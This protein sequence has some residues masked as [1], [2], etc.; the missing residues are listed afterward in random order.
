MNWMPFVLLVRWQESQRPERRGPLRAW[1]SRMLSRLNELMIAILALILLLLLLGSIPGCT[2]APS[3]PEPEWAPTFYHYEPI[4]GR[5][6]FESNI[7]HVI[8]CDEPLINDYQLISLKDI[9]DLKKKM[10]RCEVWR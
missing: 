6:R 7:F 9:E 3:R 5:C 1:L 8:D 10:L 2:L 4:D